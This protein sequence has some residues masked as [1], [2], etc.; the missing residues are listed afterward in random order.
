MS[1]SKY[2]QSDELDD[3]SLSRLIFSVLWHKKMDG[4]LKTKPSIHVGQSWLK[5]SAIQL[6]KYIYKHLLSQSI[7]WFLRT[8]NRIQSKIL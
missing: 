7:T 2:S 4:L 5:G 3:K 1:E 8:D 6:P